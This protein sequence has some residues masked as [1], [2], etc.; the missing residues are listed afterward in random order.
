MATQAIFAD[1]H[2]MPASW[3]PVEV[4]KE[5]KVENAANSST[6]MPINVSLCI[7]SIPKRRQPQQ[8]DGTKRYIWKDTETSIYRAVLD[9]ELETYA[10]ENLDPEYAMKTLLGAIAT[11]T[12]SSTPYK[13][14][15]PRKTHGIMRWT[16]EVS[17]AVEASK[18]AHYKW[19]EAGRPQG[20]HPLQLA[21]KK[22]SR[23][24]RRVQRTQAA[25]E[26]HQLLQQISE[27]SENDPKLF[28]RL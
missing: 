8:Q 26:R 3:N 9:E 19:K 14:A 21:R 18:K 7:K 4:S 20:E 25:V 2:G 28:H 15:H 6:H 1:L 13:L 23:T 27:A 5:D 17:A 11:A 16:P 10:P 22:A 12:T 24:V